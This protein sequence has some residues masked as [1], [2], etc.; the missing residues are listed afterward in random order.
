M[1]HTLTYAQALNLAMKHEMKANPDVFAFGV[2]IADHKRTFGSGKDLVELFG[3]NRYFST[4]VSEAAETGMAIGAALSGLRPVQIHARADFMLL[5]MNQLINMASIHSYLSEGQSP[6]PIT[7]RCMIGRSWGQGPQHSKAMHSTFAH[8]PGLKV[9]M[10]STPQDAYSLL[11]AA[12]QDDN[13]V[14]FFEHRWLYDIEGEVDD[15]RREIYYSKFV[16]YSVG[17][18]LTIVAS[19]WMVVE[20]IQ[21][22][23]ILED[24]GVG[25]DVVDIVSAVPFNDGAIIN[26]VRDTQHVIIADNDWAFCGLSSEISAQ[27]TEQCF[28]SLKKPPVRIGFTHTPC[29]TT[30][31]LE[32]LFYP[33]AETIVR[34]AEKLLDL[35]PIDLSQE[36]F[37]DYTNRF[38]GP[39]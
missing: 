22:A 36:S 20:A 9:V 2:D 19:S 25:V 18:N 17:H 4:P 21:A 26:S 31:P 30:R 13:P 7:V 37:N 24:N 15:E 14:L 10:P 38:K 12:I 28:S 39:F 16:K 11:R 6:V 29:P 32:T 33:T 27:I 34:A 35:D 5:A 1:I 3:S 8:F 23:R